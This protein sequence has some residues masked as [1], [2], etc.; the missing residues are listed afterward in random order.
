[1]NDRI[2]K[3]IP[4]S[5]LTDVNDFYERLSG[6][7]PSHVEP[8]SGGYRLHPDPALDDAA[9]EGLQRDH[10]HRPRRYDRL[11][12]ALRLLCVRQQLPR[13]KERLRRTIACSIPLQ[14]DSYIHSP[15][16]KLRG[17]FPKKRSS[18]LSL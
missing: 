2:I 14:P 5:E 3:R 4:P 17:A 18:Q 7:D 8:K 11:T 10:G 9:G 6:I 15:Q 1:M 16:D 12:Q 13:L